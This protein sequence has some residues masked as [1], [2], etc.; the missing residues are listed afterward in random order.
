MRTGNSNKY[1]RS[2]P[3]CSAALIIAGFCVL[4]ALSYY[5]QD[6]GESSQPDYTVF[7]EMTL[8]KD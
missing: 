5:M 6:S 3:I 2:S 4:I 8:P 1:N 7:S